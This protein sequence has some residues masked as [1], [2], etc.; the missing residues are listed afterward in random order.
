MTS[1]LKKIKKLY[2]G[3]YF[4]ANRKYGKYTKRRPFPNFA[5]F[6]CSPSGDFSLDNSDDINFSDIGHS[7]S[8]KCIRIDESGNKVYVNRNMNNVQHQNLYSSNSAAAAAEANSKNMYITSNYLSNYSSSS[9]I[10]ESDT[11][12]TA[13]TISINNPF[14]DTYTTTTS[15]TTT[16]M[17]NNNSSQNISRN[18]QAHSS[19]SSTICDFSQREN[20]SVVN[21]FNNGNNNNTSYG[22]NTNDTMTNPTTYSHNSISPYSN[23]SLNTTTATNEKKEWWKNDAKVND[24]DDLDKKRKRDISFSSQNISYSGFTNNSMTTYGQNRP[25]V[26]Y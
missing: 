16:T 12:S 23:T 14:Y 13:N 25:C 9:T 19:S 22:Y 2:K 18:S 7:R 6:D 20:N 11:N 26:Q 24:F 4:Y 17:S 8:N 15:T 10:N 5:D 1:L 21:G 3:S